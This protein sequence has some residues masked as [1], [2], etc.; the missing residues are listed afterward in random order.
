MANHQSSRTYED[1]SEALPM[2]FRKRQTAEHAKQE[3]HFKDI[4]KSL[5]DAADLLVT[6]KREI[7]RSRRIMERSG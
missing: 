1:L 3:Q 5:R 7:E 6:S 2:P 4:E